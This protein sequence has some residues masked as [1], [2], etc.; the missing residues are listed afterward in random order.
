M[1]DWKPGD[2]FKLECEGE[3][4]RLSCFGD[5]D[6]IRI[7]LYG[8]GDFPVGR[9]WFDDHA[10]KIQR[11]FQF[12]DQVRLDTDDSYWTVLEEI[13]P[14]HV[15]LWRKNTPTMQIV[16]PGSLTLIKASEVW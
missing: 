10:T 3:V 12:G 11:P 9:K 14:A 8:E 6:E 15:R 2:R 16:R 13:T 7:D 4:K 1:S 5:E